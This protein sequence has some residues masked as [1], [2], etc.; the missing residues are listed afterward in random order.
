MIYILLILFFASLISI[1]AMI[2]RKLLMLQNG[3]IIENGYSVENFVPDFDR[4]KHLTLKNTE[5]FSHVVLFVIIRFYIKSSNF[6]KNTYKG[7][8]V[9]IKDIKNRNINKQN[10]SKEKEVSKFLKKISDY[11]HKIREI[12]VKIEKEDR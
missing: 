2:G 6:S 8:K 11:K 9:K 5:N 4:I 7:L 1:S 3:K 12:K 10:V